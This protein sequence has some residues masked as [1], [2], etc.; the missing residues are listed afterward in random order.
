M[1]SNVFYQGWYPMFNNPKFF[2]SIISIVLFFN[3]SGCSSLNK[4][5][6]KKVT[7]SGAFKDNGDGT[8]TD[9]SRH[10]MWKKCSETQNSITCKT[11]SKSGLLWKEAMIAAQQP[12][13]GYKDWRIPSK[14]ELRSLIKCSNGII[15]K[16][17]DGVLGC[18]GSD[19]KGVYTSPTIDLTVFPNT[20]ANYFWTNSPL[21]SRPNANY[22]LDF[23]N[24]GTSAAYRN[25]T[26]RRELRLVRTVK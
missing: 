7:I 17:Q 20:E 16:E 5:S 12:F 2:S 8:V 3:L 18:L 21:K 1:Y 14:N 4:V 15:P 10:L 19:R 22:T 13:A 25:N 26:N 23:N 9:Q 11:N 24:G 6:P